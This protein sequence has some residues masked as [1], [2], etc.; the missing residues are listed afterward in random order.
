[1]ETTSKKYSETFR[2]IQLCG[3]EEF[4]NII[5]ITAIGIHC[6]DHMTLSILKSW[7]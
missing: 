3:R 7:H 4:K 5:E 1:M 2:S 6:A